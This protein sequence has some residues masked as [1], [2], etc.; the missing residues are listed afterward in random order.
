MAV[1]ADHIAGKTKHKEF[2]YHSKGMH[3]AY[4]SG[5]VVAVPDAD[6]RLDAVFVVAKVKEDWS[7]IA[8][9]PCLPKPLKALTAIQRI[10]ACREVG[11]K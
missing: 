1:E 4:S 3:F 5:V 7:G 8:V 2:G 9:Q 6:V 11:V 10:E